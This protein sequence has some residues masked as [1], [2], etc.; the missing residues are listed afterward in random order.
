[1]I[2]LC[3]VKTAVSIPDDIFTGAERAAKALGLSCS[4]LYATAVALQRLDCR[5]QL[6]VAA[7]DN[8]K[9]LPPPVSRE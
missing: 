2:V 9:G 3:S 8:V 6:H 7:L 1:M 4:E 5:R